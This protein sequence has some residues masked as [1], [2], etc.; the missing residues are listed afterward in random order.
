M[1]ELAQGYFR[2]VVFK[3][4]RYFKHPRKLKTS[5]LRRWFSRH[6]LNKRV[7]KPTQ[8]TFAAGLAIGMFVM[9]QL[10]PG[11][12]LIAAIA[13]AI[14]RVNIPIAIV[15]CW[16]SN[17]FTFV[18]FGWAQKQVGDWAMPFLPGAVRHGVS[19][20]VAW[21]INHIE[22]LPTWIRNAIGD[23]LLA[24]GANFLSSMYVGGLL[25]GIVIGALSYPVA[26]LTWEA[27]ARMKA[28]RRAR[29]AMP[30]SPD[31]TDQIQP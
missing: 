19:D 2:K 16:I 8:H 5:P 9:I 22:D 27:F 15:A 28:S 18:P 24:K 7:W 13:A 6:F 20:I 4:I 12:M 29:Y 17:P 14:L 31:S 1:L 11:Q 23:D 25:I 26:W 30:E 10:I 3:T 21:L